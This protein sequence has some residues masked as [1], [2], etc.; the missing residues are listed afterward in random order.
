MNSKTIKALRASIA[1]WKRMRRKRTEREQPG[2]RTCDLCTLF[3]KKSAVLCLGCPV[4]DRTG[5]GFCIGTPF[6]S[7]NFAFHEG[8]DAEWRKAATAEIK[9]LE[10]LLP[11]KH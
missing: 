7:A 5:C 11:K 2:A 4:K 6:E 9:F 1:H 10:S 8:T 3:I